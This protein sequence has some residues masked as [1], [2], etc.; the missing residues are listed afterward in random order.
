MGGQTFPDTWERA[1]EVLT[2]NVVAAL[3]EIEALRDRVK[4]LEDELRRIRGE[5]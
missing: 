1:A 2:D 4:A 5:T 3:D